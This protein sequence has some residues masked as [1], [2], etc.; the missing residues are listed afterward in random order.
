MSPD[1]ANQVSRVIFVPIN[2]YSIGAFNQRQYL[3]SLGF[4]FTRATE[5]FGLSQQV[6]MPEGWSTKGRESG[7]V[8]LLEIRDQYVRVRATVVYVDGPNE[9]RYTDI[10]F[11]TRYTVEP[12]LG[13]FMYDDMCRAHVIDAR[14]TIIHTTKAYSVPRTTPSFLAFNRAVSMATS[15]AQ[16][17]YPQFQDPTAYWE[18]PSTPKE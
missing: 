13:Y 18:D 10:M 5:N 3:K 8:S 15:W 2:L 7:A 14:R 1:P 9:G 4:V 12:E 17:H 16:K 11:N 6:E